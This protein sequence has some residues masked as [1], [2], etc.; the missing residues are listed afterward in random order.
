VKCFERL[1]KDHITL[2]GTLD[3]LQ[4]A[5]SP[6]RSKDDALAII[7]HTAL[8]ERN[9]Y[10]RSVFIDYSSGFNIIMPSKLITKLRALGPPRAIGSWTS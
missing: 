4:F 8:D 2:P 5:Y 10:V 1:G 9:T 6:N 3:P 7:L